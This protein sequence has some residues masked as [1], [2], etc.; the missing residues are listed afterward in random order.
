MEKYKS[1]SEKPKGL[2]RLVEQLAERAYQSIQVA[3]EIDNENERR[4]RRKLGERNKQ[5]SKPRI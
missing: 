4:R 3:R 2:G 1:S 5:L